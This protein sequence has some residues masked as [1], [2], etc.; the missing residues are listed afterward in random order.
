VRD[1]ISQLFGQHKR[2]RIQFVDEYEVLSSPA[3]AK[4]AVGME[5]GEA[6]TVGY[7]AL[8]DLYVSGFYMWTRND[9]QGIRQ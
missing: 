2:H 3:L 1:R 7:A 6:A 5:G 8:V 4:V 9:L